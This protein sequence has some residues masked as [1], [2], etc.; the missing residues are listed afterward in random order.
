MLVIIQLLL[1]LLLL[2]LLQGV[3]VRLGP[4][5]FKCSLVDIVRSFFIAAAAAAAVA[6]CC[7]D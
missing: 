1:L 6:E 5:F 3:A 2:L 4:V 7:G